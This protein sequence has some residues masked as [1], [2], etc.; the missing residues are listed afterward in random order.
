MLS[1]ALAQF[2]FVFAQNQNLGQLMQTAAVAI[3]IDTDDQWGRS[4]VSRI[5]ERGSEAEWRLLIAPR[6]TQHR[7]R[8]PAGWQGAGVIA[9]LRDR[10]LMSHLK[11]T[12]VP[13]VDVSAM[14][15]VESW[16]ARVATDDEARAEMA[17]TYLR[18]RGYQNFATFAPRIGRYPDQRVRFFEDEVRR[19]GGVVGDP[20]QK[21]LRVGWG[22]D[23]RQLERWVSRLHPGTAVFAADPYPARQLAEMCLFHGIKIPEQVAILSGDD[24]DLLCQTAAPGI[25]AIQ[26]DC[27][28]IADH[29]I[30][31]LKSAIRSGRPS[32]CDVRLPPVRVNSRL[33]TDR[34]VMNDT[35]VQHFCRWVEQNVHRSVTIDSAAKQLA[36][37]RRQLELRVRAAT[38]NS[39]AQLLKRVK[40]ESVRQRL[41]TTSESITR[42]AFESG[43]ASSGALSQQFRARFGITPSQV[44]REL[45]VGPR[46]RSASVERGLG[47]GDT[48]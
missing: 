33:S 18:Q 3:L 9:S 41:Q 10:A 26:L 27:Q 5:L 44:R 17:V 11:R 35:V 16:F 28:G 45:S 8:L 43:F 24:D 4:I 39:P 2:D 30:D 29:A 38:G 34:Y 36:V 7:L 25:S 48:D 37:S 31:R 47:G 23:Y 15:P 42:I 6:D 46:N 13:V 32:S 40:L 14:Y 21:A 1:C 19:Q 20:P 22:A 12:G